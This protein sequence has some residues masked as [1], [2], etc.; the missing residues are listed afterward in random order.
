[1]NTF[2]V[3]FLSFFIGVLLYILAAIYNLAYPRCAFCGKH[4]FVRNGMFVNVYKPPTF[5]IAFKCNECAQPEGENHEQTD[6]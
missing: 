6:I 4:T 5:D 1:M 3:A 2:D